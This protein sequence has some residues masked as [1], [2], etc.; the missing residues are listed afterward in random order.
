MKKEEVI[1]NDMEE[2]IAP[3]QSPY[4]PP[5]PIVSVKNHIY[6]YDEIDVTSA[7][8]FISVLYQTAL[9]MVSDSL[10]NGY[11]LPPIIVHINSYGG[12]VND[13]LAIVQAIEDVKN[14]TITSVNNIPVPLI[15]GTQIE[16]EADSCASLIACCG[17]K[18]YRTISKDSLSLLH[19]V[20]QISPTGGKVEDIATMS[21]NLEMF[22]KIF[23]NIYMRN[24][25]L[26]E[27]KFNEIISTEKYSTPEE[28]LSYGLVDKI[29]KK[30]KQLNSLYQKLS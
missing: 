16:G 6:L 11:L 7:R 28:L 14:G 12:T 26:T 2:I 25:S 30:E 17:T 29:I 1:Q 20:R 23:K 4:G 5:P 15:V 21:I 27:E 10:E 22:Q 9:T 8:N 13:A 19:E 24:S 3:M 18:G